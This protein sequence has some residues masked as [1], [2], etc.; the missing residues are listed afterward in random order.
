VTGDIG[1]FSSPRNFG[2]LTLATTLLVIGSMRKTFPLRCAV[3]QTEPSPTA[4]PAAPESTGMVASTP[5]E[6]AADF[7]STSG[8]IGEQAGAAGRLKIDGVAADRLAVPLLAHPVAQRAVATDRT[9]IAER[10]LDTD[11]RTFSCGRR[12]PTPKSGV[13]VSPGCYLIVLTN[14]GGGSRRPLPTERQ[15]PSV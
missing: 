15:V 9:Q 14:S 6:G 13:I 8:E 11:P 4:L 3:T 2:T 5:L 10:K 7:V 1:S 12:A